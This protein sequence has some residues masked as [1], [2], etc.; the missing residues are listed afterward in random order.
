MNYL[1]VKKISI[2]KHKLQNLQIHQPF[3]MVYF[4]VIG[5]YA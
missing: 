1:L 5:V 3:T 2:L 4:V